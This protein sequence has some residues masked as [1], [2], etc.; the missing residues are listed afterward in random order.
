MP[1]AASLRNKLG[2]LLTKFNVTDKKV[3]KRFYTVGGGDLLTGR[4]AMTVH[5][6]TELSPTPAI[7]PVNQE[8]MLLVGAAQVQVNDLVAYISPLA[9]TKE[10]LENKTLSIVRLTEAMA[11]EE[12]SIVSYQPVVIYG[13]AAVNTCLLRSKRR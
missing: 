9:I 7:V 5:Q 1:S 13:E 3:Y 2:K 10:E 8:S 11:E 12:Y 6:D 4:P